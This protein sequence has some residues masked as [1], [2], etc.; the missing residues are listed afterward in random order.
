MGYWLKK[1]LHTESAPTA[2]Q[3]YRYKLPTLGFYSA[4]SIRIQGRRDADRDAE[5]AVTQLH[6][7]ITKIEMT[8]EGTKVLKS[9]R[10]RELLA[11]NLFDFGHVLEMQD[12]EG[13]DDYNIFTVYL[14]AGRNLQD[15]EYMFDMSRFTDPEL[16][17]TNAVTGDDGEDFGPT[18][19]E[20]QIFGWRWMGDPIPTPVGYMR[21]DERLYY[22]TT[23]ADVVKPL[24]ITKGKRIRRLLLMGWEAEATIHGHIKRVELEVDEGVY[25]PV[26]IDNMMEWCWQNKEDYKLD[27]RTHRC[28]LLDTADAARDCDSNMCY[29]QHVELFPIASATADSSARVF[30]L[31]SGIIHAQCDVACVHSMFTEGTGYLTAILIGFDLPNFDNLLDTRGMSKLE[32]EMTEYAD[33]DT[34]SVVVEEEVLY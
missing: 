33:G 20:Y 30:D 16:A 7:L 24:E 9:L 28:V 2:E 12:G 1:R 17:I 4:F 10:A 13:D 29:P 26:T 11:L 31:G 3:T 6:E 27:I 19:L 34:V 25:S 5:A 23:G 15:K 8:S 18:E 14:L 32:L 22:D 21:A